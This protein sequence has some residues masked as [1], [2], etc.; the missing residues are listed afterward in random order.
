MGIVVR[1]GLLCASERLQGAGLQLPGSLRSRSVPTRAHSPVPRGV[2]SRHGRRSG[3]AWGER[4]REAP[5]A[6]ALGPRATAPVGRGAGIPR[7][8]CRA[9]GAAQVASG[10]F[11]RVSRSAGWDLGS[12]PGA[13]TEGRATR[14]SFPHPPQ[15]L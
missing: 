8:R 15:G 10:G 13:G 4:D 7:S 6:P 12:A 2:S 9:A 1:S 3:C 11:R 5:P 14:L